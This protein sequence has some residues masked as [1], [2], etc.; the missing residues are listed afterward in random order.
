LNRYADPD[1]DY[2]EDFD[3]PPVEERALR[4]FQKRF[5]EKN[6][7]IS[8]GVKGVEAQEVELAG[9]VVVQ[10]LTPTEIDND[11]V[12]LREG[13]V[14][15]FEVLWNKRQVQWLKYPKRQKVA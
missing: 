4:R 7:S 15:N 14:R 11:H 9:G 10:D 5:M 1:A 3:G 12:A 8:T 6:A 13:L 2:R